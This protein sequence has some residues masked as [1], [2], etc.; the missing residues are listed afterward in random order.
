MTSPTRLREKLAR[1]G[2][3][4]HTQRQGL[5]LRGHR[6]A[7]A[8]NRC[9]SSS[10]S[11]SSTASGP[12]RSP[13]PTPTGSSRLFRHAKAGNTRLRVRSH[14]SGL[15]ECR[16][17]IHR[18]WRRYVGGVQCDAGARTGR[19]GTHHDRLRVAR[20][21]LHHGPARRVQAERSPA[22]KRRREDDIVVLSHD[23]WQRTFGG[24]ATIIGRVLIDSASVVV[25][26][27]MSPGFWYPT[28]AAP[29]RC[30]LDA[31][32]STVGR[33]STFHVDSRAVGRLAPGVD[34]APPNG[35]CP[36]CS[37]VSRA[38]V[39]RPMSATGP[40]SVTPLQEELVG[41]VRSALLTLLGAVALILLVACVNLVNLAAVRGS[42]RGRE[43]AIRLALGAKPGPGRATARH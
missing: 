23:V 30:P 17:G 22:R 18:G 24:D 11:A 37:G 21:L 34:A 4:R 43:V 36:S 27:V 25:V 19:S 38:T 10:F 20:V 29:G 39:P 14:A 12:G 28:S 6:D 5:H 33:S 7:R 3:G 1:P 40:A 42:S 9:S 32:S 26:G 2:S 15:G 31:L 41:D 16:R 13:T 35:C 8:W